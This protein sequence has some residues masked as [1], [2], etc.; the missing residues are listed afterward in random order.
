[1][2]KRI[3]AVV[4]LLVLSLNLTSSLADELKL[5][6]LLE[7]NNTTKQL[8]LQKGEKKQLELKGKIKAETLTGEKIS[9]IFNVKTPE[10]SDEVKELQSQET[11]I[12]SEVENLRISQSVDKTTATQGEEIT[13]TLN[14]ENTGK[15]NDINLEIES[16]LSNQLENINVLNND[17]FKVKDNNIIGQLTLANKEKISFSIIGKIKSETLTGEKISNIFNVKSLGESDE[18]KELQSQETEIVQEVENLRMSQSVDKTTAIQGEEIT[19]T[20]NLENT[21]IDNNIQVE[22]ESIIP[23]QLEDTTL[24]EITEPTE[25]TNPVDE[26]EETE[27]T[28][29]TEDTTEETQSTEP[30]TEI[31]EPTKDNLTSIDTLGSYGSN[32]DKSIDGN[33]GLNSFLNSSSQIKKIVGADRIGT[34]VQLSQFMHAS[35]EKV[36]IASSRNYADAL[37]A[38]SITFGEYPILLVDKILTQNIKNEIVR[39]GAKEAIILGGEN[40]VNKNIEKSLR[41]IK[42]L[43]SVTRIAGNDRYD[44]SM[45]IAEKSINKNLV[46]ASGQDYPDALSGTVLTNNNADLVLSR[47]NNIDT[48]LNKALK[49]FK[50]NNI[51]VIGGN[52]IIKDSVYNNIKKIS[53]TSSIE[54]LAGANRYGTSVSVANRTNSNTLI[55]A[56]GEDYPDALAGTVLSQKLNAPIL[57]V[58]KNNIDTSVQNYIKNNDFTKAIILGGNGRIADITVTNIQRLMNKQD[59]LDNRKFGKYAV[60]KG[61]QPV[62]QQAN[63]NS[64]VTGSMTNKRIVKILEQTESWLK[65][66]YDKTTGWVAKSNVDLYDVKSYGKIVNKVTYV[67][68]L[69]PVYAPRGCEPTSLLMGLKGKGK[70]SNVGL[71][72]FLDNMPRHSSNPA[73]GYVS[74]PYETKSQYFQTIDPK[75]LAE[76]GKKYGNVVN[77]QNSSIDDIIVE[78]QNGN[79]VVMYVTLF[80]KNPTFAYKNIE[81]KST[82]RINNNH[83]LL[84]TGYDPKANKFYVADPY[85]HEKAGASRYSPFY[86]WKDKYTVDK[87]YKADYR[88]FS[89]AVR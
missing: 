77:I 72:T 27:P 7:N 37:S 65:V 23:E 41:G 31:T 32:V 82:R 85:N 28:G 75:P 19:Y 47:N 80:W 3:L 11:E 73:K 33:S 2:K 22:I 42:S 55:I 35:S 6:E 34:A 52:A 44:T 81:G 67:S 21:S 61:N 8:E 49:N 30:T 40:A 9:N 39:I 70:A 4:L 10:E 24:T 68:Q 79:T 17:K 50:G 87:L 29:N 13:Y 76:Y 14:V 43:S 62:Y 60:V 57:L 83:V 88:Y 84:L 15:D 36:V 20:L 58:S 71:R 5:T 56:S 16:I 59:V 64:K 69:Y 45:R 66:S 38:S 12:V 54:R 1:M 46:I 74:T 51:K 53:K 86:Y 78:L 26:V 89:V 48:Y 18:V 63:P 25:P